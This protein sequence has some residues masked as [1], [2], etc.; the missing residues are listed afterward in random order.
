[1]TLGPTNISRRGLHYV[2]AGCGGI[3]DNSARSLSVLDMHPN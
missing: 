3:L 2:G 1:M